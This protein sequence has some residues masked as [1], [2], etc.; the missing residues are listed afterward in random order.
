MKTGLNIARN[1]GFLQPSKRE[2]NIEITS[3]FKKLLLFVI[4]LLLLFV[5]NFFSLSPITS[6]SLLKALLP[7][8]QFSVISLLAKNHVPFKQYIY[9]FI[10]SCLGTVIA[11]YLGV[12]PNNN[13][14]NGSMLLV[15]FF[16]CISTF[17]LKE[18]TTYF[19]EF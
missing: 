17:K 11:N 8:F 2:E 10:F 4:P 6:A 7:L 12:T 5:P 1:I 14:V 16:I 9:T 3:C 13:N 18:S 15:V 19:Q